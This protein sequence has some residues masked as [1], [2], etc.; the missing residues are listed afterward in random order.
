MN[1]DNEIKHPNDLTRFAVPSVVLINVMTSELYLVDSVSFGF[2]TSDKG[3]PIDKE[4]IK[5][6]GFEILGDL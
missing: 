1:N 4:L 5:A 2:G 6:A 3:M